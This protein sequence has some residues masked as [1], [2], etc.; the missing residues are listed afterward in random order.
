MIQVDVSKLTEEER[1]FFTGIVDR[2]NTGDAKGVGTELLQDFVKGLTRDVYEHGY[3][4]GDVLCQGDYAE[5]VNSFLTKENK[6]P[7]HMICV[8]YALAHRKF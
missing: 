7:L 3:R 6:S 2:L 1:K 4:L 5:A 8:G